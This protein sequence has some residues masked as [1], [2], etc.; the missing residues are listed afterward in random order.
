MKNL[1]MIVAA[2]LIAG[3]AWAVEDQGV[4][5]D[6]EPYYGPTSTFWS[7][8]ERFKDLAIILGAVVATLAFV[9]ELFRRKKK[10]EK[11]RGSRGG[12]PSGPLIQ[13]AHWPREVERDRAA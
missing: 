4:P 6:V 12:D 10:Q 5:P 8:A 13:G 7:W 3:A 9:L 11:K 2:L 1:T